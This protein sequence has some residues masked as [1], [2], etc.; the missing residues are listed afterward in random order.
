MTIRKVADL[1]SEI[2]HGQTVSRLIGF[3]GLNEWGWCITST[4][5]PVHGGSLR[6]AIKR[7]GVQLIG[8]DLAGEPMQYGGPQ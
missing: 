5:E 2:E 7:G 6:A 1:I 4:N 8:T 3:G